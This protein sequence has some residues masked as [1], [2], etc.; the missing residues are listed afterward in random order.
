MPRRIGVKTSCRRHGQNRAVASYSVTNRGIGQYRHPRIGDYPRGIHSRNPLDRGARY[1]RL[2]GGR[3]DG[4][5]APGLLTWRQQAAVVECALLHVAQF[6]SL[7]RCAAAPFIPL[8]IARRR[9]CRCRTI[10]RR[11]RRVIS[12]RRPV[13]GGRLL[14]VDRGRRLIVDRRWALIDRRRLVVDRASD[15]HRQAHFGVGRYGT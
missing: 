5:A 7:L 10:V 2:A 6:R 4:G 13:I 3:H 14:I 8:V 11:R 12:W 1:P 9:V 15:A